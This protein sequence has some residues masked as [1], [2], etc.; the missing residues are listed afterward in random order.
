MTGQDTFTFPVGDFE[1]L[2]PLI[3]R[4]EAVN[5]T[6]NCAYFFEDPNSPSTFSGSFS[7]GS[8]G[9]TLQ[10]IS[11]TEFW[12]LECSVFS[13]VE[14]SWNERSEIFQLTDDPAEIVIVGW[15]KATN[16]WV[17]LGGSAIGDLSQGVA[18]S[19]AFLPDNYAVLTLGSTGEPRDFLDL[20]DY[21]VSP[22]GDGVNEF[23]FIPELEL[24]PNNHM[25]IY[26]RNGLKVFDKVNYTNDFNGFSTENNFVINRD[27]GLPS[28][29]YFYIVSMDD[30]DLTFQGF[31][32]L[33][34]D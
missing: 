8:R 27:K 31:L 11:T 33:A 10:E 29:V 34:R 14:L 7:T 24:S 26:D 28:G 17:S 6:A 2:R 9:P 30:L 15:S 32:Y 1:Q 13:T 16:E 5:T 19:D 4:S 25:R 3:L 20:A 23:L 18:V 21:L 12:H 22:N